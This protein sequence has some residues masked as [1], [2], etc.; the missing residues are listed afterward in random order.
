[1]NGWVRLI[2]AEICLSTVAQVRTTPAIGEIGSAYGRYSLIYGRVKAQIS[3]KYG[4]VQI[5]ILHING[6]ARLITAEICLTLISS[7]SC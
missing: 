7:G 5:E 4:R 3:L 2:I 6:C 1:M